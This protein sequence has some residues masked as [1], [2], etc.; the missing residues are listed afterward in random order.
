MLASVLG[1]AAGLPMA[2][3]DLVPCFLARASVEFHPELTPWGSNLDENQQ[4][5]H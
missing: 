3:P 2:F 1:E 4:S 5:A